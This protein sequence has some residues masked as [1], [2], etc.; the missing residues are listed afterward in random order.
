MRSSKVR[1]CVSTVLEKRAIYPRAASG[2]SFSEDAKLSSGADLTLSQ[3]LRT[4]TCARFFNCCFRCRV[5]V[6]HT[7][8]CYHIHCIIIMSTQ[9]LSIGA[10]SSFSTRPRIVPAAACLSRARRCLFGAAADREESLRQARDEL[11]RQIE[12]DGKRWNFDFVREKPV[13]G[14]R[15]EWIESK[16]QLQNRDAKS[17][18]TSSTTLRQSQITGKHQSKQTKCRWPAGNRSAPRFLPRDFSRFLQVSSKKS[19][20]K[21]NCTSIICF[22]PLSFL[23]K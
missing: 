7:P 21:K 23:R 18:K 14:L 20:K 2:K 8:D 12:A 16:P 19:K 1:V 17:A 11:Q 22:P 4:T 6:H 13:D 5:F 15:F 9:V 10:P 3:L